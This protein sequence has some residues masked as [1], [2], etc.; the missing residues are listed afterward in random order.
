MSA[1]LLAVFVVGVCATLWSA[2]ARAGT[3]ETVRTVDCDLRF[4]GEVEEGDADKII[5]ALKRLDAKTLPPGRVASQSEI[6][7]TFRGGYLPH[8][9][10]N[11]P[12]GRF[13]EA[14]KFARA[15]RWTMDFQTVVEAGAECYS[16]CAIIFLGGHKHWGDGYV[17]FHRRLHVRGKLG[18]HAPYIAAVSA[19]A[20]DKTASR[21]YRA[22]VLA[23]ADLL[24]LDK[25]FFPRS[26]L[27]EFLR[28][29][30]DEF[31][32]IERVGQA[33]AFHINLIGYK[34]PALTVEVQFEH[35]CNN[36]RLRSN[37]DYFYSSDWEE[38]GT[39]SPPLRKAVQLERGPQRFDTPDIEGMSGCTIMAQLHD[40]VLFIRAAAYEGA[41]KKPEA[42]VRDPDKKLDPDGETPAFFLF[43]RNAKITTLL[44]SNER[45]TSPLSGPAAAPPPSASSGVSEWEH[46]GSSAVLRLS[47]ATAVMQYKLP[48]EGMRVAGAKAG[49]ELFRAARNGAA[50]TGTS[51]VFNSR[52]GPRSFAVR[53]E[54]SAD[55]TQIRLFGKAPKLD[56]RCEIA[57]WVDQ[58]LIFKLVSR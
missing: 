54:M 58:D 45:S 53:G 16:A 31:F 57:R 26:L 43:P 17:V 41:D 38:D 12:G 48:R 18:F 4:T 44:L 27:S 47:A 19:V 2:C 39:S 29:G 15:V 10:L 6:N 5:A 3:I 22:G 35:A 40:E 46:N 20:D 34:R 28:V 13:D 36:Y 51:Q 7:G 21:T 55:G 30:P 9:C 33:A 8:L 50:L 24:T 11:S 14:V 37:P 56:E 49:D 42:F 23:V 52:C 1:R 32:L 25:D